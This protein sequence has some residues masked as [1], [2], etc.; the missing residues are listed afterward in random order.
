MIFV[1][2]IFRLMQERHRDRKTYFTEL[3]QTSREYFVDYVGKAIALTPQTRVFE[4]GCGEGGN[5]I[6]FAEMGCQV[7]GVDL[8]FSKVENANRFFEESHLTGSF[9]YGDFF[10]M[11]VPESEEEKYDLVIANDVFEHI[12]PP[13]KQQFLERMKLFMR[14]GAVAFIGFPGWQMPFGGH[15]QICRSSLSKIPF[16]HLLPLKT[17]TK[18]ISKRESEGMVKELLSIR[19]SKVT[20]E[21]FAKL[22]DAAGLQVKD[23]TMWLIN[24]HYKAKFHL[25]PIREIWPFTRIPYFRNYYTTAAWYLLSK[26]VV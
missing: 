14:E 21:S 16:L 1:K 20:I 18:V 17:F 13:Y 23:R 15:Q 19:R 8:T 4:I 26:S 25:I 22:V 5:L 10:K 11:P 2:A 9:L 12:E 7:A 6:P 24:P 3:A